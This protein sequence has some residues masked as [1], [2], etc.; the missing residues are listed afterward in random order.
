MRSSLVAVAIA[1]VM[2]AGLASPCAARSI[3]IEDFAANVD[4]AADGSIEVEETIRLRFTGAWN[5]IRRSIPVESPPP[6]GGRHVVEVAA[7]RPLGIREGITVAVGWNSGVIRRLS[8]AERWRWWLADNLP[9][10]AACSPCRC[11]WAGFCSPAG[12]GS[13][14]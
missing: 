4:V 11:P 12:G 2:A 9:T 10:A 13:G 5:G 6:A 1:L 3:V 14:F 7:T 8:A